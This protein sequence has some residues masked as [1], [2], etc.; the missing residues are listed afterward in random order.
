V[1]IVSWAMAATATVV[2]VQKRVKRRQAARPA[3]APTT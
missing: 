3:A 1:R 2:F